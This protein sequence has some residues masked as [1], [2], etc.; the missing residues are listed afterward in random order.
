MKR[1]PPFDPPEYV[2]W[3]PDEGVQKAYRARFEEEQSLRL[4]LETLG[5]EGIARLYRGLV[6][7]R[8]H[9]VTLKRWVRTGVLTKAW[10]GTGEEATTIGAVHA[11]TSDDVVGPMIRNA[12]ACFERGISLADCFKAY[13]ATGD[14]VTKGRDLHIGDLD[15]GVVSPISHVGDL[16]PVLAGQ[17]LAFQVRGEKRV[18]L[19][20]VGDGAT[21]TG[22]FHEGLAMAASR[23]LPLIVV[24]QDNGVALGTERGERLHR[25]LAGTAGGHGIEGLTCDGNHVLDVFQCTKSARELC[26]EG[27]GPVVIHAETFRMGGHA[28]HDEAEARALFSEETFAAWG[29]RDPIGC[30]EE[31]L[32]SGAAPVD[33]DV[34]E[35]LE[36]WER[37]V[38]DEVEAAA[39]AALESKR[40]HPPD[41]TGMEGDVIAQ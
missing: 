35:R 13:L 6:R 23:N 33:G 9:D 30:F 12:A 26:V 27:K 19:T 41:P 24:V 29:A 10:L 31:F 22:A 25:A 5:H 28:T 3:S 14:T 4:A 20:W 32:R 2:D 7:N 11:L 40:N 36:A 18:A 21:R 38:T 37:E 34:G 8:L 15:Y 39:E 16:V 17:A 1:Y